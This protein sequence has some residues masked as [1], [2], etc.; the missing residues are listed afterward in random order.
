MRLQIPLLIELRL[1]PIASV[2]KLLGPAGQVFRE[3]LLLVSSQEI[4]CSNNRQQN[5]GGDTQE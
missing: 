3:S 5:D 4:T 2:G 1:S